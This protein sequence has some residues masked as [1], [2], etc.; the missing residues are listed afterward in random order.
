VHLSAIEHPVVGDLTYGSTRK[1]IGS[2]RTFLHASTVELAHPA[3]G[4]QL[5]VTAPLPDDLE[6]VLATLT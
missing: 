4:E 5:R 3:T 2:P 6:R 1:D